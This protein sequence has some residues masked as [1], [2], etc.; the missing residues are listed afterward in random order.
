MISLPQPLPCQIKANVVR[1]RQK[2][3]SITAQQH[4]GFPLLGVKHFQTEHR[5]VFYN[6]SRAE[7]NISCIS[8]GQSENQQQHFLPFSFSFHL[9][10]DFFRFLAAK[11]F[12][13]VLFFQRALQ[14]E[15][16]AKVASPAV[17][18][19]G[20]RSPFPPQNTQP[21]QL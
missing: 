16:L 1:H 15:G 18:L 4:T 7:T 14:L 19:S 9:P 10:Q 8:R 11:M 5:N 6:L 17:M 3:A 12:S 13:G 21:E 20:E 2:G